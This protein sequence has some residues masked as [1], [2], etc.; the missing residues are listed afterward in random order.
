MGRNGNADPVSS[1]SSLE[2]K[3]WKSEYAKLSARFNALSGNFKKARE[4]L[5]K[6]KEERDRWIHHAALLEKKIKA[7]EDEHGIRI[8][9]PGTRQTGASNHLETEATRPA[10]ATSFVSDGGIDN[11]EAPTTKAPLP[12]T[13]TAPRS[14]E[15]APSGADPDS[16]QGESGD[17]PEE[18]LP[19]LLQ[20]QGYGE[21]K[22][23]E[24]PS[25]DGPVFVSERSLKK[26]KRDDDGFQTPA[27]RSI[28]VESRG[29][30]SSPELSLHHCDFNPH[31]SPDLGDVPQT[32]HT[33]RK[34]RELEAA[35]HFNQ[36]TADPRTMSITGYRV[37]QRE[38]HTARTPTFSSALNPVNV[39]RQLPAEIASAPPY[40][41]LSKGLSHGIAVLAED[42]G[43]YKKVPYVTPI[44]PKGISPAIKGRL[45]SLLNSPSPAENPSAITRVM[46]RPRDPPMMPREELPIPRPR[47]LPFE[48]SGRQSVKDPNVHT[49]RAPRTPLAD[50]TNTFQKRK[51]PLQA[52]KSHGSL[53]RNKPLSELRAEDF[54][55]NP[56]ANDGHD[57]AFS[58]V[59]RD[60]DE[61]ACLSGCVDMHCCGKVFRAHALA[62][63][64]DPP[65]TAAQRQDEQKLLEEY[66]GDYAYRLA[67]I[68]REERAE[69]WLEAKTREL[70]DK[71]GKHRHRFSRMR[72]PPGFWN[73]DF[74][75]TQELEADRAEAAKRE[76]QTV[77][78]RHREAMRPGG[79]WMFRDE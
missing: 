33:P 52:T 66:L 60:K 49:P 75:S 17:K 20:P 53:L 25:S 21:V 78:D 54:K 3:D 9:D 63:R 18:E 59:V 12:V 61:R 77:Q 43:M 72:S 67:T 62:M 22:V 11:V 29:G 14:D 51:P 34:R 56:Q 31:E 27:P 50:T 28:K 35:Q 23:K 10:R 64:P 76:R 74:P 58:E 44:D 55:V 71:H 26:R 13:R 38:A 73:A 36:Q 70:A 15:D 5:Q 19:P 37:R 39:N 32:I 47:E 30:G 6:R 65:L 4:A 1:L 79:R 40:K 2:A 7:A 8:L 57:F 45:D 48:S 24:E 69:L 16:T 46:G 41:P 68:T 42:G